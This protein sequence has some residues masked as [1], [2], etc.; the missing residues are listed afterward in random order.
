MILI[1]SHSR[2]A[3][4][5]LIHAQFARLQG[6]QTRTYHM[7]FFTVMFSVY[8]YL[9][10]CDD[11]SSFSIHLLSIVQVD[12]LCSVSFHCLTKV[13]QLQAISF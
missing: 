7:Y 12:L 5:I 11:C 4:Q 8:L 2:A 13:V 10:F 6:I 3:L 1:C 9:R